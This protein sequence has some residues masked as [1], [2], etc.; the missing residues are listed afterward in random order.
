MHLEEK[1]ATTEARIKE[2]EMLIEA[3]KKQIEEKKKNESS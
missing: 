2:L 1:I 3:W